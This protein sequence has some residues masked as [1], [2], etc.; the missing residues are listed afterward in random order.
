MAGGVASVRNTANITPSVVHSVDNSCNAVSRVT[1]HESRVM[2]DSDDDLDSGLPYGSHP[3]SLGR[4]T[5][6]LLE[7]IFS[8][9]DPESVKRAALVSRLVSN[10]IYRGIFP[11]HSICS[12]T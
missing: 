5:Q 7:F 8:H 4:G 6:E 12:D 1:C 3:V 10:G 2:S 9:L 11:F